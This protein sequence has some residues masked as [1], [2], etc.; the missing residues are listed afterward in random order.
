VSKPFGCA[1]GFGSKIQNM[2]IFN[3]ENPYYYFKGFR[4]NYI[5]IYIYYKCLLMSKAIKNIPFSISKPL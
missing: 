2:E 5:Y 3:V 1:F 4:N